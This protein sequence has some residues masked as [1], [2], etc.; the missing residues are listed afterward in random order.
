M[1]EPRSLP[2]QE[3]LTLTCCT[4]SGPVFCQYRPSYTMT[5]TILLVIV[6]SCLGIGGSPN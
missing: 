4:C 3:Q 2:K 1:R 5:K 6:A